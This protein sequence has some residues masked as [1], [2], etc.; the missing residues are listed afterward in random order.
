MYTIIKDRRILN[1]LQR[2]IP[3]FE[4]SQEFRYCIHEVPDYYINN[5]L[6][7]CFGYFLRYFSG[8]FYPYVCKEVKE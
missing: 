6:K 5:V 1:K 2:R 4:Y 8:C 7:E 3:G